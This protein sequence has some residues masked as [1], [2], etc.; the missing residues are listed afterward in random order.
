MTKGRGL[1]TLMLVAVMMPVT[2]GCKSLDEYRQIELANR[3]LKAEKAQ[4]ET[5][6]YDARTL[7]DSLRTK[8]AA[9]EGEL[10]VKSLLVSN[11]QGENDRLETAFDTC[12]ETLERLADKTV[13]T[14]PVVIT[15]TKLPPALDTALKEFARQYPDRVQY[16]DNTGTIKWKSDVLFASGSDVVKETAV[17]SLSRF[18]EIVGSPAADEFEVVVVGHTDDRQPYYDTTVKQHPT[19]WHLSVHRA[20]S[21]AGALL[22]TGYQAARIGVMGYGEFRPVA[23]NESEE[24]RARNRRVEIFLIERGAMVASADNPHLFRAGGLAFAK[25]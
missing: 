17:A 23:P 3:K 11:L 4:V 7:A 16:D 2:Q 12:Q 19:N 13:P 20:I 5:E 22:D 8:L 1:I 25:P 9:T 24:G 6:L 18:A 21:V 14:E 15:E 10:E